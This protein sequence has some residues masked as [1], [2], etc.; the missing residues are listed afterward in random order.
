MT[1]HADEETRAC[2]S[3]VRSDDVNLR[4]IERSVVGKVVEGPKNAQI[5]G[6][7][8]LFLAKH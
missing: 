5:R 4:G 3:L 8:V 6:K 2:P 7:G 1:R